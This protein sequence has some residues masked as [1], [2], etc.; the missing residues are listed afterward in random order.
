MH[1]FR[2]EDQLWDAGRAAAP[3]MGTTLADVLRDAI[4]AL[5]EADKAAEK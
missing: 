3:R 4:R 1:S 2:C 5:L